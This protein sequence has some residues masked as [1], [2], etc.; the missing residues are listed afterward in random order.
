MKKAALAALAA[1]AVLGAAQASAAR[2]LQFWNLTTVTI[3]NLMLAPA[4]TTHWST[5]QCLNDSDKSVD[6]DERLKLAGIKA[7]NYDVKLTD[8]KGRTCT[9]K[10]VEV[11]TTGPYAFSISDKELTD[12]TR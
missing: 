6:A 1:L 2:A 4:G 12:C 8:T 11:K 10:N 3:T 9:V 7:G 5:N